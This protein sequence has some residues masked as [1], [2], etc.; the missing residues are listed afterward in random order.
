LTSNASKGWALESRLPIFRL[1]VDSQASPAFSKHLQIRHHAI[2]TFRHG[3]TGG[4]IACAVRRCNYGM[5][6]EIISTT[7]SSCYTKTASHTPFPVTQENKVCYVRAHGN[8]K[9]D[10]QTLSSAAKACNNGGTVALLD[11]LYTIAKSLDL[12]FL[13][14]I[15]FDIQAIVSRDTAYWMANS[16]KYA[17]Q[18]GSSF[19]QWGGNDVNWYAEVKPLMVQPSVVRPFC[20]EQHYSTTAT[21]CHDW[22]ASYDYE[23]YSNDKPRNWFNFINDSSDILISNLT[24][25][26][27]TNNS[28]PV[29][30]SGA[31][32]SS[33]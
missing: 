1:R 4:T 12:T 9:G 22:H 19:W 26:A 27:Q 32:S 10:S 15:E 33:K 13:N 16:F 18:S 30:N 7:N 11:P 29:K 21:I 23:R 5:L 31:Y 3:F 28:N 17:F 8:G 20:E 24:L 25:T 2:Q 6:A 14:A